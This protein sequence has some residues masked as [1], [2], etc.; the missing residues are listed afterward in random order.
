MNI[1]QRAKVAYNVLTTKSLLGTSLGAVLRNYTG[2]STLNP[3]EQLRGITYKAIDKIGMAVS[4]YEPVVKRAGGDAY[5]NHPIKNLIAQPN[6][7]DHGANFAH[8]WAMY[9]EIYGET[10]FY[11]AKGEQT[12]KVKE[13]YMLNP[14]QVELVIDNGE[15]LGY[16]LHKNNGNQVPFTL[17]EVVH[18]KLPNPFNEWRGMSVMER[19]SIYIDTEI[20][21]S[22]FTL[23][24]MKNNASPSGIVSLPNMAT[25]TFKQFTQQWRES[26]EGPENAG[27]TAFIRGE[28]AS[29]K[30]VGATLKDIDQKVTRDM[31]KD[32]VLMM[33]DVP[34]GLLGTSGQQG[35]GKNE[36]EPLEYIFAKYKVN[37]RMTR[38]DG[39]W[40]QIG[41]LGN[42]NW[43]GVAGID[44]KSPI[45]DDTE[46]M[47]NEWD[48]GVGRWITP[49][50]IRE[51]K[52][53]DPIPGGDELKAA[54]SPDVAPA[55]AGKSVKKKIIMKRDDA[56]EKTKQ[57]AADQEAFRSK[58]VSVNDIYAKKLKA[59][60][61]TFTAN[62]EADVLERIDR[63]TKGFEEWLP[64]I[65][66][67]AEKLAPILVPIIIELM[68]AQAEDVAH[69][70]TGEILEITAEL[71]KLM[72]KR[73]LEASAAFNADTMKALEQTISEGQ[74]QGETIEQLKKRVERTYSD[75][76]GYRAE[77]IART[78]SLKASNA[79]AELSYKN[80]GYSAVRWVT[81]PGACPFCA[82]FEGRV[83][84]I[85]SKYSQIGDVIT[86]DAGDQMR[87]EYSDIET[88]PLH[89]NCTCSL[90]P[91]DK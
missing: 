65:K 87:I 61:T 35:L 64:N 22:K 12:Q 79:T 39:I 44:H 11:L 33:F 34:K 48:K 83:K 26:Y 67:Q 45:P 10:F 16:V 4:D 76:K 46:H 1:I 80:S 84:I 51:E 81:N 23:N 9:T 73:L 37:P 90:V 24:Y 49:N 63:T 57:L 41:K 29:F 68:K 18:D 59:A 25:E 47:L 17:D 55:T 91:E 86:T 21:T 78:E 3:V 50:E 7:R 54:P 88:P 72:Q 5:E 6:S 52:G 77:R 42:L 62:Q 8:L 89:P 38:Y 40:Q 75:A 82:T 14:A 2:E 69:F 32:D 20:V 36:L 74:A 85:G 15:L 60:L 28:E 27:K 19:A 43:D 30:A 66:E 70:I 31:A 13:V 56:V 58:L 53:L 71:Q